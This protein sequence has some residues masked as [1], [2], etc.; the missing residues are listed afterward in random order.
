VSVGSGDFVDVVRKAKRA[1]KDVGIEGV[2]TNVGFLGAILANLEFQSGDFDIGFVEENMQK[3]AQFIPLAP[4]KGGIHQNSSFKGEQGNEKKPQVPEGT[5]SIAS[6]MIGSIVNIEVKA[7]QKVQKGQA[8]VV[9]EAMKMESV[10]LAEES[11]FVHSIAVKIGDVVMEKQ[12]LLFLEHS[13]TED[14]EALE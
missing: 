5:I 8:L 9:M 1:L 3:L 10:I 12:P 14:G 2:S 11:G 7:G 13:E 4:F 6:P